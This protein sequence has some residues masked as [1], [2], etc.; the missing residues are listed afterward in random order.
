MTGKEKL[1][2]IVIG[3]AKEP[4]FFRGRNPL[5][6]I[7]R[8]NNTSWMTTEIFIEFLRKFDPK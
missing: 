5:P 6:I 4:R 8:N 2:P 3:K 1:K 7:Y